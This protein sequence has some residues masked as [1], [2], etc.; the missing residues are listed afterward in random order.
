MEACITG[1]SK[2]GW[3]GLEEDGEA[4]MDVRGEH[5]LLTLQGK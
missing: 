1:C 5:T 2:R 3:K 4:E